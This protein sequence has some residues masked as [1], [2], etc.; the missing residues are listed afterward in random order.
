MSERVFNVLTSLAYLFLLGLLLGFLARKLRLPPLVGMLLTGIILGPQVLNLLDGS[1]LSIS[2]ELR[3]LALIIILTRAGLALDIDDLKAAGRPAVLMCFVPASFEILGVVLLAPP[4]LGVSVVEAAVM[5]AVLAA[6]SPAVVVP[7][8]LR[9]ME[10]GYGSEHKIPQL[11]MAGASADD[12]FVIVLFTAFT[13]LAKGEGFSPA[14]LV[15]VPLAIATG[16]LG[17]L[18]V[19][20]LLAL[21]FTKIHIRD[22]GKVLVFL[23]TSFLLVALEHTLDGVFP[24]SGLLAVMAAG[25]ALSRRRGDLGVRLSAKF[26][27]LWVAAELLLFALVGATVDLKY[28]LAAGG[29]AVLVLLGALTFRMGGVFVCMLGSRLA[30]KERLFCMLAYLPKATVQAAIGGVPLSM[31]LACGNLVLTVAVLAILITAPLGALLI[32]AT[33]QKLLKKD[34]A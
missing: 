12:V 23:S 28:A 14:A 33:Y 30:R 32:D 3:Q 34:G 29:A 20:L 27:K 17:G 6:V 31:G 10:E 4:L 5:G 2:A 21:F 7:R 11:I 13:G 16:V 9:L 22:T 26:S 24:F 8:M 25:M 18:A 19:G 1:L 15:G